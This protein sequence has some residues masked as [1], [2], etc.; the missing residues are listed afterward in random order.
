MARPSL[1]SIVLF[2]LLPLM[3]L[4][5]CGSG[6]GGGSTPAL[7]GPTNLKVTGDLGISPQ[8]EFTWTAPANR[9]DGYEFESATGGDAFTKLG[10]QLIPADWT[11]GYLSFN[12]SVLP[13]DTELKFRM[14]AV[15]G[16]AASPYSNVVSS[17]TGL[18]KPTFDSAVNGAEGIAL[19]W[20]NNSSLADTL[21]LE[22]G[23]SATYAEPTSWTAI[24]GVAFGTTTYLDSEAPEN[25]YVTYR[26][27]YSKGAKAAQALSYSISTTLKAPAGLVATPLVEGV[28]LTWENRSAGATEVVVTRASG[29]TSSYPYFEDVAHL[30]ATAT[31]YQDLQLA[32]GYYTYRVEARKASTQAAP[33]L[34]AKVVTLPIPGALALAA[35][36]IKSLP[37]SL[38]GAMDSRGAWTFVQILNY[39]SFVIATPSGTDWVSHPLS[40]A[41]SLAAPMLQLD[42][43]DRP[44][45]VYQRKVM[46]GS[47][48]VAI[49]HAWF[50][51][52]AWQTEEVA[53]R[54]LTPYT[55]QGSLVFTLDRSDRLHL[56]WQKDGS[57][58]SGLEYAFKGADGVWNTESLNVVTPAPTYLSSFRLTV[59][60]GGVPH[61]LVGTWQDIYLLQRQGPN[62][63]Q[64]EQVPSGAAMLLSYDCL[65]FAV[66]YRGDLHVFFTRPHVPSDQANYTDLCEVRKAG[67]A[68]T[69]VQVLA[70]TGITGSTSGAYCVASPMSDRIALRFLSSG[71]QQL[72]TLDQDAWSKV[73]LGPGETN[74]PYLGFDANDKFYL[75]QKLGFDSGTGPSTYVL[76]GEVR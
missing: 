41:S 62:Q 71:G 47:E 9:I 31:S 72:L 55:S 54:I 16:T 48:E 30:A 63:W 70:T 21:T 66:S 67:G 56:A 39:D 43:H 10:T 3:G 29:I 8:L 46:Q 75:M 28:S 69:P 53:R 15:L 26:V 76:Y 50:D 74:R 35:P 13:E 5:G 17:S 32:T 44:H 18:R 73:T 24:P 2:G 68:W 61:V 27:T 4:A 12:P 38:M 34:S 52:A 45:T 51:G 49:T 19:K 20:T 25:T 58:I 59:D 57:G 40:N 23:T 65:D 11:I 1:W 36:A 6:G 22:R 7:N 64:W 14:R 60:A 37:P 33:S 42:S